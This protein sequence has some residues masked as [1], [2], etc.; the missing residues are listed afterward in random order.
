MEPEL[1]H[2]TEGRNIMEDKVAWAFPPR[3]SLDDVPGYLEKLKQLDM[4][5]TVYFDLTDTVTIHSSFIGF[6][7]HAK[8]TIRGNGGRLI[9]Q[10]STTIEKILS[11]LNIADYFIPEGDAPSDRKT[12]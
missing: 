10:L 12:A 11:R 4:S 7:I 3:I 9:L 5:G 2:Y 1:F 8:H 6:L